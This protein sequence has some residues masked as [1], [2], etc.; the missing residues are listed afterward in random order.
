MIGLL[1]TMTTMTNATPPTP[2]LKLWYKTPAA[3]W[4]AALPVG[5]G[6][7]GAM[8]FGGTKTERIQLNENT[9]WG[10]YAQETVNPKAAAALPEVRRL[11]FAG[12][13]AEATALAEKTMLG[14]PAGVKSYQT[15]GDL[16]LELDDVGAVSDY[17]RDLDLDS[18][19]ATT[20]FRAN[21][22]RY[23]REVFASAPDKALI[24]RLT[25]S[26]KF[27]LAFRVR[28]TRRQ[29]AAV[30]ANGDTLTMT[31]QISDEPNDKGMK[32]QA[33]LKSVTDGSVETEGNALRIRN[34]TTVTLFLAAGTNFRNGD[35]EKLCRDG[36]KAASRS[37]DDVKKRHLADH[38]KFFRRVAL[39]LGATP[40]AALPTDERLEAV[41]RGEND[42]ALAALYFQFGRYLLI[43]SSR[44]NEL[45]ANLQ[46]LWNEHIK[47][48]WGSDY[49]TN[50]N[51]QMN[52]WHAETTNLS[53]CHRPL[54]DF[55]E[56]LIPSGRKT[57]KAYYNARGWVVHHLTD[58]W[59]YTTPADGIWGVWP[60]GAAWLCQHFWE[61]FQ[62]TGDK[63]WLEM[64]AYPV[65]KEAAEFI[66]DFLAPEPK[67]GW[68]VTAPSHSPENR[69]RMPNGTES[70]FTYGATMDLEIIHDL[71]SHCLAA[72]ELLGSDAEF[73]ARLHSALKRLPP[74]Q[75]SARSGRLQEWLFDYEEPEPGHRH[76]SH[77]FA[78][79]PGNQIT[80]RGTPELAAAARKSLEYRLSHGG[81][82][83]GWSRAWIV[84]FFARL[85][86]GQ[87]AHE[88][89]TALLAKSTLPNLFDN[90]PPFQI[91]GN[92]G[93]SAGIAEMLLQ[94]HA[95]EVSLLPALPSAWQTGSVKG[96]RA[97]GGYTVNMEWQDG[98]LQ[99]ASIKPDRDGTLRIR[100]KTPVSIEG[101]K[102]AREIE[103]NVW[104]GNVKAGKT[105]RV[106]PR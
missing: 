56:T 29:D 2:D 35:P 98:K 73:R 59:G 37:F 32:F 64:Q 58:V 101:V 95:G 45:P 61:H 14:I 62:F 103:P 11:L 106:M 31:G 94:S 84:N 27:R 18:G 72:S 68:L 92:F 52:Y 13:P 85:E 86:D 51:L 4:N 69:Y 57:A 81:G 1:F 33:L 46:G 89:L 42:P 78:L 63:Q 5:N 23:T 54:L 50:V 77:L 97:R 49:H 83:T 87:K 65:M 102:E 40:N 24:V 71:F 60:M 34:A 48:P 74:L 105:Y 17:R 82:H 8:V 20:T 30:T 53:E 7:L 80:L 10:G 36:L 3:N 6:R 91:D 12:K 55:V 22:V 28:L 75:I 90:H 99:Q 96:L 9:L 21:G 93:G 104:Q 70:M 43:G 100:T 41:K 67:N 76:L 79:H 39:D 88:H 66:L 44:P 19:V 38:R 15:L 47:A 16:H 25:S 26:E